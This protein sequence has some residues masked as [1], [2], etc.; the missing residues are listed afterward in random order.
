MGSFLFLLMEKKGVLWR[1]FKVSAIFGLGF[2]THNALT[3]YPNA[4][5]K[6]A[7]QALAKAKSFEEEYRAKLAKAKELRK[8]LDDIL[9][10][11]RAGLAKV[12]ELKK[13]LINAEPVETCMKNPFGVSYEQNGSDLVQRMKAEEELH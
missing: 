6:Q 1:G 7:Q 10:I 4:L 12:E 9:Q 13:E 2:C 5:S 11:Y 8:E 3:I